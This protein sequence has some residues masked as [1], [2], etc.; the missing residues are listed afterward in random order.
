MFEDASMNRRCSLLN[1]QR[2]LLG[3]ALCTLGYSVNTVHQEQLD[4]AIA[5][6]QTWKK[7]IAK[8]G[9]DDCKLALASGE[10]TLIQTYS[11]DMLQV[12]MEKPEIAFV[13][14]EE[15]STVTFDNFAILK[16]SENADLAHAFIN[17]M[18]DP[19]NC[20]ANMNEI[21]YIAPHDTA[22]TLVDEE[23]KNNPVFNL[24]EEARNR[25]QILDDLG[26]DN[27]KYV[28]AWDKIREEK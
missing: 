5:L 20:A 10:F 24:P 16:N 18:Y 27:I 11:G 3:A 4:E 6:I 8:F 7:N 13:I 17:F 23:L 14:P 2:E 25:C 28:K 22:I 9:V 26:E 1:D 15:G 12:M 21:M 19:E